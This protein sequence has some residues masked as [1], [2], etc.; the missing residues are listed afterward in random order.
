MAIAISGAVLSRRFFSAASLRPIPGYRSLRNLCSI[1]CRPWRA[2][3]RAQSAA[4]ARSSD[5]ACCGAAY[6]SWQAHWWRQ[7][8]VRRCWPI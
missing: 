2:A 7:R 6:L 4:L 3:G 8:I 5:F 1:A